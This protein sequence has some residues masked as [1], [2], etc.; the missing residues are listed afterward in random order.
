[1]HSRDSGA[2]DRYL[3]SSFDYGTIERVRHLDPQMPTAFL[4]YMPEPELMER[5]AADGHRAVH[6]WH[7]IVTEET[8]TLARRLG[9]AVN[10]WT[11]DDPDQIRS[12]AALGVDGVVTNV[13][14]VAVAALSSS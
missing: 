13:P 11:V 6:P 3:I 1:L 5:A 9:L 8:M 12:L 4:F 10:V 14:D 2:A 7:G